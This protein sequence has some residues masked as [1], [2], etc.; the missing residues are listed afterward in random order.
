MPV[1]KTE[2]IKINYLQLPCESG[3]PDHQV[4]DL[5]MIHGLATNMAFWYLNIAQVFAKRFRVTLYDLRGHGRSSMP[6]TGYTPEDHAGD[7]KLLLD[8]LDI[9][10]TH[11]VAHS[12][13]AV[14]AL[15]FASQNPDVISSLVLADSHIAE[16]RYMKPKPEWRYAHV[17]QEVLDKN[18]LQLSSEDPYFGYRLLKA[19]AKKQL[20]DEEVSDDL[21]DIINPLMSKAGKRTADQWVKL[22]DTTTA[23]EELMGDDGLT[24][25]QLKSMDFPI[26]ALYGER[27]QALTTGEKLLWVWPQ[28]RFY[29][30]RGEGHFFPV[31]CANRVISECEVFWN[32]TR[33]DPV[34]LRTNDDM[35]RN[36]FRTNRFER[37]SEQWFFSTR[38]G[39]RQGP[40][41][42]IEEA[43][44]GLADYIKGVNYQDVG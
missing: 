26:L 15:Q 19:L 18:D 7:L 38:E 42:G 40:F 16:V 9:K 22:L 1:L 5:V 28:A 25:E 20:A 34:R 32:R 39:T 41:A 44:A 11:V 35:H 33:I 6:E 10:K 36:Y 21:R 27:S 3:L 12:F 43:E 17:I 23:E 13:G 37:V 30:V 29:F 8:H 4:E 31:T 2:H 14:V 24:L